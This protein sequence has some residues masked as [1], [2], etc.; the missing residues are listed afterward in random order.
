M[1]TCF[2]KRWGEKKT[3]KSDNSI[4]DTTDILDSVL[5]RLKRKYRSPIS[6][7]SEIADL[8]VTRCLGLHFDEEL[9]ETER[10]RYLELFDYSIH[11]IVCLNK[12]IRSDKD[13]SL[14]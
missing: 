1:V 7:V 9:W 14:T 5:T 12:G 8:I 11:N 10:H 4:L 6:S 13:R 2:P 3:Y